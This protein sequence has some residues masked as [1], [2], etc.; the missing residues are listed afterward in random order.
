MAQMGEF[1]ILIF[2]NTFQTFP[3]QNPQ[4]IA[5]LRSVIDFIQV[6]NTFFRNSTN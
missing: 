1:F 3:F 6:S 5:I 4:N 2:Q